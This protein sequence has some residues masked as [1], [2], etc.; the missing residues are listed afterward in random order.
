MLLTTALLLLAMDPPV[1]GTDDDLPARPP[2]AI[3]AASEAANEADVEAVVV[4][5]EAAN[6][7]EA[8][9]EN[10]VSARVLF[11]GGHD[12]DE[13]SFL[14]AGVGV[15]CERDFYDNL[16]AVEFAL[17]GLSSPTVQTLVVEVVVEKPIELTETV[18]VYLGAGPTLGV[19]LRNGRPTPGAGGLAVFGVEAIVVGD[20]EVFAELDSAFFYFDGVEFEAD[21]GTGVLYR[22]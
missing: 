14:L 8:V 17:E 11:G 6:D 15:A 1:S 19:H 2:A 13:G 10:G 7:D 20:L 21:V 18:G 9:P 16:V 3:Q 22:F 12:D 5:N 4:E